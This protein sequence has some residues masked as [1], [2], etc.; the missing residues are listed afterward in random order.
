MLI[1]QKAVGWVWDS[2]VFRGRKQGE[3]GWNSWGC[4]AGSIAVPPQTPASD[5]HLCGL[6]AP[7]APHCGGLGGTLRRPPPW[8]PGVLGRAVGFTPFR[9]LSSSDTEITH[10]EQPSRPHPSLIRSLFPPLPTDCLG[11]RCPCLP[12]PLLRP[13]PG[14]PACEDPQAPLVPGC[15]H[16]QPGLCWASHL[17]ARSHRRERFS[18]SISKESQKTGGR[19][20][21]PSRSCPETSRF[22]ADD[23]RG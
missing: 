9:A 22:S 13:A 7:A 21:Y 3:A 10:L 8:L 5:S 4:P 16:P 20:K 18:D 15:Q 14:R 2:Y 23:L 19:C 6:P 12:S 17:R 1:A 11:E